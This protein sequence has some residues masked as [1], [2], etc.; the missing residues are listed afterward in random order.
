MRNIVAEDACPMNVG[1]LN[2]GTGT[3]KFVAKED[4]TVAAGDIIDG[5]EFMIRLLRERQHAR[6]QQKPIID[7]DSG[8]L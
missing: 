3:M 6:Q 7:A 5:D 1:K 2:Q 4:K 8:V